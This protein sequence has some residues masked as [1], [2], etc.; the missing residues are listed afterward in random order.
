MTSRTAR[1]AK[2]RQCHVDNGKQ[3]PDHPVT[4]IG[5]ATFKSSIRPGSTERLFLDDPAHRPLAG[6]EGQPLHC[7]SP[8][9]RLVAR[10][11]K[12]K[13]VPV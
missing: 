6:C 11:P 10:D 7:R 5:A 4:D 8:T 12:A 9:M 13:S 2:R 1:T 3:L